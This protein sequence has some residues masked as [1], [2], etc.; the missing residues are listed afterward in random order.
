MKKTLLSALAI[1]TLGM[2]SFGANAAG[3]TSADGAYFG[4]SQNS[5]KLSC[6]GCTGTT[7]N[8]LGM[9]GGY[10]MGNVSAEVSRFQKTVDGDKGVFTDF[11]VIPRLNVAQ[12]IDLLAKV[13]FRNTKATAFDGTTQSGNSLVFGAGVEYNITPQ[14]AARAMVDYSKKTFAEDIR[15]VSTNLGVSYKF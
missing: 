12:D 4:V 8:G 6:D 14:L 15:A 11:S 9:F 5:V 13:G 10:R 1:A 7:I 2:A 3:P